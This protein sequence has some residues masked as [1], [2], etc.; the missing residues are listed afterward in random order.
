MAFTA[1]IK[2]DIDNFERNINN[3]IGD[4][5]RLEKEV[6]SKTARMGKQFESIGKKASIL[7]A[8]IV[9]GATGAVKAAID[10]ETAFTGVR[11]TVNATETEFAALSEGIRAMALEIPASAVAIA[12]VSEAAGQLGIQNE[13][14]LSFTRTMID[15]GEA[16][17]LSAE[18][19]ATQLARLANIMQSS[20]G[21][22]DRLGST[23]VALGNNLATTEAEISDMALRLAGAGKQVGLTEAQVL[24]LAGAL[25][26]VGIEAE[27]GG[28]AFSRVLVNMQLAVE[29]GGESLNNFARVA[30]MTSEQFV[31]AF[32]TDA[33]GALISFITGL[34]NTEQ[35]GVSAIKVLDDMGI[36]EIRMR[37]ALLRAAGAGDLMRES[38][39]LGTQAWNEN[40]ALTA[41]AANRYATTASQISILKNN[42]IDLGIQFGEI[43]L[44]SLMNIV[45]GIRSVVDWL[46]NLSP[47]T[48]K[49]ILA[50]AG[51]AAAIGPVLL[52]VGKLIAIAPAI[53]AAFTAM[54]GPIGIAIAA[55]VAGATLIIKNWDNIKAY[56]TEGPGAKLFSDI[57]ALAIDLRDKLSEVF[58]EI[59]DFI[60]PI[61]DGLMKVLSF[62][63]NSAMTNIMNI[64]DVFV[65]AVRNLADFWYKIVHLD[66]KGA[67]DSLKNYFSD[68][69]KGILRVVL[70]NVSRMAGALSSLFDK[71]GLDKIA[72][73]I[74][75]FSDN[76]RNSLEVAKVKEQEVGV[77]VEETTEKID[78]QNT[79]VTDTITTVD[80]LS[81]S[82]SSL[83]TQEVIAG[84]EALTFAQKLEQM[85][86][87]VSEVPLV[88][89]GAVGVG[90][91]PAAEN[92][93][94]IT[95][96]ID[97]SKVKQGMGDL[98]EGIQIMTIDLAGMLSNVM[99]DVFG[100]VSDA[101]MSGDSIIES[102]GV[103]LLGTMGN[104]MVQL[105]QMV[106]TTGTA[107]EAV[108]AALSTL[109]GLGAIAAGAALIAIGS[110]FAAG[111]RKLSG[112]MG[113]GGYASAPS[114]AQQTTPSYGPS[115]YRGPYRD[116]W[117]GNVT[118][119]I[120]NNELVGVLEQANNRNNRLK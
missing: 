42:V 51:I 57:K 67:L 23:I 69:F 113:G 99:T 25:S 92:K 1:S 12:S 87:K 115:D 117:S 11:K 102:L 88:E 55:I 107:I 54:T 101:I 16:T 75:T 13:N 20:Q 72:E 4:I 49:A 100:A 28:S 41:E 91:I 93:F 14:I 38:I 17:N 105:G 65:N 76:I 5:N 30:G 85:R 71:I 103:S 9:A 50:F 68:I 8:G 2:A 89:I 24:S 35:S 59:R 81:G 15:L 47:E 22:F 94:T 118:F 70:D 79:V 32:Q 80:G 61:W 10:Y 83:A 108:K 52:V 60:Q 63:F 73:K 84:N 58:Q 95:P 98:A 18:Q 86:K 43:L 19:A 120:G 39:D 111:A 64:L 34:Q 119:R 3:A 7:S 104:I 74:G 45:D 110:L 77:E 31:E 27:S 97:P 46:R 33:A 21:D 36:V 53:G 114:M 78:E 106:I 90:D 37:D 96:E 82:L 116:D 48:Q 44:P 26:S 40:N 109:G 56:F 62:L 29:T 66:F 6:I 112:S